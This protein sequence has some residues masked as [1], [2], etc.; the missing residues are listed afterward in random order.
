MLSD[1]ENRTSELYNYTNSNGVTI[2]PSTTVKDLGGVIS[3][4][5][6]PLMAPPHQHH[7][8]ECKQDIGMGPP[9]LPGSLC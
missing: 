5:L 4:Q 2:S 7:G 6:R 9:P 8:W 3:I 1:S